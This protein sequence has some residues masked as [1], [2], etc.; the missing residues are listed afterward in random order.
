[1]LRVGRLKQTLEIAEA[2]LGSDYQN[3]VVRE[4]SAPLLIAC[5]LLHVG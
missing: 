1:M 4:A 2:V 3:H 5:F